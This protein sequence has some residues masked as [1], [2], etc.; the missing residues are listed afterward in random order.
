MIRLAFSTV[1]C[2]TWT[3]ERVARS[4]GEW[5]YMGVELRSFGEG[6]TEVACDPS[7][8]SG[9]K[10]REV[11]REAGVE[12]AGIASGVRFDAAIWPPV[13]G[14]LLPA[15]EASVRAGKHM[16]A[17]ARQVGAPSVRVFAFDAPERE[18]KKSALR[19]ICDRLGKVCD[20]ARNRDVTIL[21]EN[22]GT[23]STADDLID[24]IRR[25]SQPQLAAS[26]DAA[27]AF[28]A[29][30]SPAAGAQ[31][32]GRFLRVA[33]VRDERDGHACRLGI[34]EV[35][36]QPFL[37]AVRA[38]DQTWGTDPWVVYSWDRMWL[39][40]LSPAEE[41]LPAAARLLAQ[42]L[43]GLGAAHRYEAFQS[44]AP[45]MRI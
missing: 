30:E 15:R 38:A 35:P 42:W 5:G 31:T 1:A 22:G 6:G 44:A 27:T 40:E 2:H 37:A 24:I 9:A 7:L 23:F 11:F 10:V 14:T 29:G 32:L 26:Y 36:L 19:R 45:A 4:A 21:I 43:G 8:T 17:V 3:L 25:V 34:G 28:A 13:V 12:V 41:V 39:P 16:V 20:A 33:R 18:S